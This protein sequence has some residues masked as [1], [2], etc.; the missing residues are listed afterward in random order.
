MPIIADA[1]VDPAFGTGRREDHAGPRPR[2]LR[3]GP[4]PRPAGADDPRRRRDDR[5][6]RHA[7]RRPGPLRGPRGGSSPTSTRAATSSGARRTRWSSA[8]AS[9]A[10]TSSSRA[11]RP[12]GSSGPRRWPRAPSTPPGSGGL[13]IL[14]EH[15]EKTW[16]H[17]LTEHPRLERQPPA[18]VGPPDPGLVLPGRPRDRVVRPDGPDACEVCGRPAAE[19]AAGPRHLRHVVQ[20]AGCGRSRRSAGRTTRPTSRRFYPTSVMETGYDILFFWVARMVMLGLQLTDREPFHT[21][22]LSGLIRDPEGQ[23]M[24]KTKGNVV[25]P[26]GDHRRDRAP[27]PSGSR[28]IHG[29]AR[30]P[31]PAL[32]DDQARERPQLRE[33][34][35]ERDPLRG[36]RPAGVDRR[37]RASGGC[38]TPATSGPAERWL[39]SRAAATVEAVDGAM[40]E[41][42]FGEVTRARLRRD[43]ERVLRL[44]PRARQGPAHRRRRCRTRPA[45]RRGGR[46]SRSSTRTCGC[47]IR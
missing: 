38:P 1:V 13:R 6:H 17:W 20:L 45:R 3:D 10:T 46:S 37:R 16:E 35:L 19:L 25:D 42:A 22:Y 9:A 15:F 28:S 36:R 14:P 41:Y 39:R 29:A 40:A 8:A 7:L 43:L 44:G 31:G 26:L 23:K 33:Q 12:S 2:R 27:T 18:V 24:S 11:S 4:A 34:A 21:V 47:S 30:R 32:R 5:Q